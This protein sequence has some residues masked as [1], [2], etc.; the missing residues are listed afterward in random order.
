MRFVTPL[1]LQS[2]LLICCNCPSSFGVCGYFKT[3]VITEQIP[4]ASTTRSALPNLTSDEVENIIQ[5]GGGSYRHPGP[6]NTRGNFPDPS[7]L[8]NHA[9]GN[10]LLRN[11]AY[12]LFLSQLC[13]YNCIALYSRVLLFFG[14]QC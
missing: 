3:C 12:C 2:K 13:A 7:Y 8:D 14:F 5:Q 4:D 9:A 1:V 6:N 10:V 11:V